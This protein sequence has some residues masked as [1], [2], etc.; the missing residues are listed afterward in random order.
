MTE[1]IDEAVE[2]VRKRLDSGASR[3]EV[4]AFLSE[5]GYDGGQIGQILTRLFPAPANNAAAVAAVV[6]AWAR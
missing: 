4:E 2:R 3:A 1:W 6:I 5:E